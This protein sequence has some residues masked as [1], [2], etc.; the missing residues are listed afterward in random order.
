M[1]YRFDQQFAIN[2]TCQRF[3]MRC[4]IVCYVEQAKLII[5]DVIDPLQKSLFIR[6]LLFRPACRCLSVCLFVWLSVCPLSCLK[7]NKSKFHQIFCRCYVRPWLG[8]PLTAQQY[9]MYFR[10]WGW[11][12]IFTLWSEWGR[13]KDDACI[14]SSLPGDGSGG[15]VCRLR[16]HLV[17]II[18]AN[19]QKP[20]A[21]F[22]LLSRIASSDSGLLL[23]TE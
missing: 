3:C 23:H 6:F 11:R 15:E 21:L 19:Q 22:L 10:F 20:Q 16:L 9:A 13:I 5:F 14:L 12:P 1:S 18:K 4:L 17:I 7:N 8:P 2:T